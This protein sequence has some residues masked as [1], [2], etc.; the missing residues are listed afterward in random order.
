MQIYEFSWDENTDWVF[1]SD[2]EEAREFYLGHTGCGDLIACEVKEVPRE[3][4]KDNYILD[5]NEPEPYDDEEDYNEED[6]SCGY[7][8]IESFEEYAKN[9][10]VTDIICTTAF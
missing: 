8:I 7:K 10:S 1:A 5:I 2:E 6:Y 3:E 4:W 9:N